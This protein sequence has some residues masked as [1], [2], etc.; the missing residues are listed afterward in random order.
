MTKKRILYL[1]L[2]AVFVGGA[3]GY[4]MWNK[5]HAKIENEKGL[6]ITAS[7]LC[8]AFAANEAAATA[9][10]TSKVLDITGVVAEVKQNQEGKSAIT[11]QGDDMMSVQCTMRDAD[12]NVSVGSSVSIKGR[13]AS[14]DMFGPTLTDCVLNK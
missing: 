9:E 5:P 10:Y 2:A 1:L 13:F 12:V 14:V 4:Y 11:L 6:T 7:Q 3:V 8:A